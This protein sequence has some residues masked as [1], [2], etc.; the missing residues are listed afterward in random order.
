VGDVDAKEDYYLHYDMY[1]GIFDGNT[2]ISGA[3]AFRAIRAT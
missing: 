1:A 3:S 2:A